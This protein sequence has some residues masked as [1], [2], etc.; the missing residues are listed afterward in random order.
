MVFV[1]YAPPETIRRIK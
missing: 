1:A